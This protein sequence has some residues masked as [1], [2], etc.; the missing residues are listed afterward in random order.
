MRNGYHKHLA[1][2]GFESQGLSLEEQPFKKSLWCL[3]ISL[4]LKVAE[5]ALCQILP[6]AKAPSQKGL[7][8]GTD[9]RISPPLSKSMDGIAELGISEK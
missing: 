3:P 1:K 7:K 4:K 2:L 9:S 5:S 8:T 6:K